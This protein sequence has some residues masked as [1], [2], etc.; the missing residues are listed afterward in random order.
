MASLLSNLRELDWADPDNFQTVY[1]NLGI[2]T[3]G[4]S[5]QLASQRG[6]LDRKSVV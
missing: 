4:V 3:A 5:T 6:N 2:I 1:V